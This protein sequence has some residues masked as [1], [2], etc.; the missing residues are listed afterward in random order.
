MDPLEHKKK[1]T[2]AQR[3]VGRRTALQWLGNGA[4]LSL[5]A[6]TLA[7]CGA[8]ARNTPDM[9]VHPDG[10]TTDMPP[11]GDGAADMP[12]VG[13]APAAGAFPFS[14]GDQKHKAY[15]S[16]NIRTVD[17]QD[18]QKILSSWILTVDGQVT[19]KRTY[20]FAQ[21]TALSRTDQTMDFHCVEGWSV[22]DVPWNGVHLS[23]IFKQ[24]QPLNSATHVAFHTIGGQYNESLPIK[25]A[26]E[27]RTIL[28][29]GVGGKTLPL[30]HGFPLRVVIPR[31]LGYKNAKYVTRIELT[32]KPLYGFWVKGGYSYA[33]EVPPARLRAGKY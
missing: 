27:Q 14:P 24:V 16:W 23:E 17:P 20:T 4:V 25:I 10:G 3:T 13:D 2:V 11:I 19:T 33:G 22:L 29:Y 21:L 5:G 15:A 18:L 30:A 12:P 7:A 28:G 31:L 8:D 9:G 32:S 6:A 26:K 1:K